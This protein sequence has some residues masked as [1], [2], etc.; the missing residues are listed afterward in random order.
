MPT[1]RVVIDTSILRS[2]S[3]SSGPM[4][5]LARFAEQGYVEI[6]VPYVVAK[7][8]TT[9]SSAKMESMDGL[10]KALKELRKTLPK[11]RHEIISEF[12]ARIGKEFDDLE[13]SAKQRFNEWRSRTNAT[14]VD[15]GSDHAGKVLAQYFAGSPP[16]TAVKARKDFPDGFIL[17]TVRDL[18]A[19]GELLMACVDGPL[20]A[21]L[22]DI[23]DV[24]T[25]TGIK[26]LMDSDAFKDAVVETQTGYETENVKNVVRAFLRD[27]TVFKSEL[28]DHVGI[29]VSGRTLS[30][31]N[32]HYDEKDGYD[33]L[34]IESSEGV[35][36][37]NFD[38]DSDYLGEGVLLVNFDARVYVDVDDPMSSP[39]YDDEERLDTTREVT[40]SGV[41]TI[42]LE[43]TILQQSPK[44][45]SGAELQKVAEISI[46]ELYDIDLV[47]RSY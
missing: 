30:Y 26:E 28:E 23:P 13:A 16:F 12:E 9:K 36:D 43:P 32:P 25:F 41:I 46:D 39:Y 33:E 38:G 20:K 19:H 5:A 27:W 24:T 4:E 7:E 21:A 14:I 47:S 29:R 10:R 15:P 2:D 3:L 18:A 8:F 17:E 42:T 35:H 11:H 31:R 34:Y 22:E 40:V 6:V 45:W 1:I 44:S 37:W